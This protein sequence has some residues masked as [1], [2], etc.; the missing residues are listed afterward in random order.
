MRRQSRRPRGA[1]SQGRRVDGDSVEPPGGAVQRPVGFV[2]A[3]RRA[4]AS[5]PAAGTKTELAHRANASIIEGSGIPIPHDGSHAMRSTDTKNTQRIGGG[6][7]ALLRLHLRCH[8]GV[9]CEAW[10]SRRLEI[11]SKETAHT[12][13]GAT[14]SVRDQ[15]DFFRRRTPP[16]CRNWTPDS[17]RTRCTKPYDRPVE[18]AS[19]RMLSPLVYRLTKSLASVA[20]SAPTIRRPS[21]LDAPVAVALR[22]EDST[23]AAAAINLAASSRD[24]YSRSKPGGGA[25]LRVSGGARVSVAPD[26]LSSSG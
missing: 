26:P 22:V 5:R 24:T 13:V 25:N 1:R 19:D 6:A 14:L 20:R 10:V 3:A 7:D 9:A 23:D 11:G 12:A 21:S 18:D 15:R 17:V 2:L 8:Q 16:R 4:E